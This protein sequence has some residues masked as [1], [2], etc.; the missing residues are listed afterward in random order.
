MKKIFIALTLML[1]LSGCTRNPTD[2]KDNNN[3]KPDTNETA[4]NDNNSND[5]VPGTSNPNGTIPNS[6]NTSWYDQFESGL[7]DNNFSYTAKTSL[8]PSS[9]GGVEGYRY[10][11]ENGNVDVYRF[12][13][14]EK[15]DKIKKDKKMTIN[16]EEKQ[17]EVN[18]NWV[19]VNDNL[20]EDVLNMFRGL[21]Q[22]N[23]WIGFFF[24]L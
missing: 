1:C 12:D 20:S 24:F 8:D 14:G 7:R 11:G 23:P 2:N 19:I 22:R 18:G 4:P 15:L 13:E 21:N 6:G 10:M 9:I 3:S 5:T 16:G 17:V